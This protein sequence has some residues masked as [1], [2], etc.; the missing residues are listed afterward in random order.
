MTQKLTLT[1]PNIFLDKKTKQCKFGWQ[2]ADL[3]CIFY[4]Q[5]ISGARQDLL[6]AMHRDP[7]SDEITSL[8][9]RLFP[10]KTVKDVLRSDAA[11]GVRQAFE[12]LTILSSPVRL[13]PL[14]E[15]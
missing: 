11:A 7:S 12:N 4:L 5:N 15:E 8:M 14:D 13:A 2:T 10:G 6:M 1:L 3:L 9:A